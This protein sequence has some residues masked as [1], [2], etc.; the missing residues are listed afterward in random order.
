M[1]EPTDSPRLE[2]LRSSG[3]RARAQLVAAG[4]LTL[5]VPSVR[6]QESREPRFLQPGDLPGPMTN[7]RREVLE[8]NLARTLVPLRRQEVSGVSVFRETWSDGIATSVV[9]GDANHLVTTH[10]FATEGA[11]LEAWVEG[12]WRA[13]S[14]SRRAPAF[15]LVV[16]EVENFA[17]P[18]GL[19]LAEEWPM[20]DA[21]YG[22]APVAPGF[23]RPNV[24]LATVDRLPDDPSEFYARIRSELRNGYP[25]VNERAELIAISA[26]LA[27]DRRGGVLAI[28]WTQI[29]EWHAAWDR[30]T[31]SGLPA[32]TVTED[33]WELDTAPFGP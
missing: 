28:P 30:A 4:L 19:R 24:Q 29:E 25:F 6:A 23:G 7:D 18:A 27:Q 26:V 10:T 20:T 31:D 22:Y 1:N 32:P 12:E 9:L 8:S 14:V 13:T 15:D 3:R 16:L 2:A 5:W 21:I 33:P 11:R 17:A